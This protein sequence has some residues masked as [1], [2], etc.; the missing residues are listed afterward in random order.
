VTGSRAARLLPLKRGPSASIRN[1]AASA[2]R[3]QRSPGDKQAS[4]LDAS[5]QAVGDERVPVAPD[6]DVPWWTDKG[7]DSG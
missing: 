3:G 5:E 7:L 6:D 2:P 1:P 4:A